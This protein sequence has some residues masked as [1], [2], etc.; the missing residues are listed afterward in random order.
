MIDEIDVITN[1]K[2]NK[3]NMK[4]KGLNHLPAILNDLPEDCTCNCW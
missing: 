3:L 2:E 1:G 4:K